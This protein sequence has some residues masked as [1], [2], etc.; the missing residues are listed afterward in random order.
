MNIAIITH[1]KNFLGGVETVTGLLKEILKE[2]GF[3]VDVIALEDISAYK[4]WAAFT[5]FKAI[6]EPYI[7]GRHFSCLKKKYDIVICN[8]EFGFGIQ[9][10]KSINIFHGS[11]YGYKNHLRPFLNF[12]QILNLKLSEKIQAKS[13]SGKYVV[14]VSEFTSTILRAQGIIVNKVIPNCIDTHFF[15]PDDKIPKSE[16]YLFV[17]SYDYFGK[18]IDILESLAEHGI[19]I[20]CVTDR[21]PESKLLG[22]SDKIPFNQMNK[23]YPRYKALIFP[24][25]FEG[26]GL[27]SLEAMA[28]GLPVIISNVGLGREL[29]KSHPEFVV[30]GF[31]QYAIND[32]LHKID[33]IEKKY[34]K[35]STM[36]LE[37]VLK[38][39]SFPMFKEKWLNL[40]KSF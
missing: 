10:P 33:M 27:V 26:M 35:F 9:H 21:K 13:A 39:H 16:K 4:K 25:R 31:G 36:A 40:I 20:D 3:S 7:I 2:A 19:K 8:G 11:Y 1:F 34:N 12:K 15:H 23:V 28:C 18:G 30:D 17:G 38:N 24:S 29:K 22:W 14:A 6:V 32:Y 5:K 37:Y